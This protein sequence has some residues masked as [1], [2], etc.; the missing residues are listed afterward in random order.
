MSVNFPAWY[1]SKILCCLTGDPK[2]TGTATLDVTVSDVND[3]FPI[4]KEDYRPVVYENVKAGQNS[5]SFPIEVT[6][7]MFCWCS[8]AVDWD[9]VPYL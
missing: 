3:N 2:Q 1:E 9:E 6:H 8:S 7:Y 4:F 5:V